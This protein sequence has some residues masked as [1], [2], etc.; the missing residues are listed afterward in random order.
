MALEY[1]IQIIIRILGFLFPISTISRISQISL[2]YICLASYKPVK[3][4]SMPTEGYLSSRKEKDAERGGNCFLGRFV[5]LQVISEFSEYFRLG[6]L[7]RIVRVRRRQSIIIKKSPTFNRRDFRDRDRI[8][9]CNRLIRSQLLY[10][11]ELRG[12]SLFFSDFQVIAAGFKPAT[13]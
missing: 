13:G 4:L 11:V 9:T 6:R 2:S 12:H 7:S 3:G 8:Q 1:F 5:L 10:S